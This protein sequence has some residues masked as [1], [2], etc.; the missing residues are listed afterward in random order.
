MAASVHDDRFA[1][2]EMFCSE[3]SQAQS[4]L[5]QCCLARLAITDVHT[6]EVEAKNIRNCLSS[7]LRAV[8]HWRGHNVAAGGTDL[9]VDFT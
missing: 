3:F 1:V 9:R 5:S 4:Q 6:F 2:I 8:S 7:V